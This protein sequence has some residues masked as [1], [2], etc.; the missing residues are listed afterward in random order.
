M[1]A[2]LARL[3]TRR[4]EN[5]IVISVTGEI[6]LSNAAELG[7]RIEELAVGATDVAIDLTAVAYMDS[8]GVRLLH[9]LA[10]RIAADDDVE[11]TLVAPAASVAGEVLTLTRLT[12]L[13]TVRES[14]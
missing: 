4:E 14:Q 8:Q 9:Q 3:E 12:D 2:P 10:R 5:R 11:L 13:V 7:G 1:S 6:D